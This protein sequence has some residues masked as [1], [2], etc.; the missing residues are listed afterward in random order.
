MADAKLDGA[1]LNGATFTDADISDASFLT[2]ACDGDSA[3]ETEVTPEQLRTACADPARPP[4]LPARP[5][6]ADFQAPACSP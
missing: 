2:F 3:H 4:T 1:D 6:F 5:E